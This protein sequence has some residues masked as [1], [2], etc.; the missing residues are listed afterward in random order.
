MSGV[1]RLADIPGGFATERDLVAN[2]L[3]L[4]AAGDLRPAET[5]RA[6]VGPLNRA[7]RRRLG[8]AEEVPAVALP[9]GTALDIDQELLSL[10]SG[11]DAGGM[12]S[13]WREFLEL[14]GV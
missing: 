14:H 8:K 12:R 3:V 5:T 7:L 4:C 13:D 1:R 2:M 11:A 10:L 9:C 6:P